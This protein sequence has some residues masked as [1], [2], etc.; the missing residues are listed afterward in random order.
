MALGPTVSA[1]QVADLRS[2]LAAGE[3]PDEPGEL[4]GLV[5]EL[6][7]LKSTICARQA[8]AAVAYDAARREDEELGGVPAA[9]RGR[10][11]AAELALAR[12]ESVHRGQ[13]LLAFAKVG[14]TEMPHLLERLADGTL[15]EFRA[16]LAL[17]ETACL[18]ADHRALVDEEL[19]ADP[20]AL[21]GIGTRALV[22]RV[23]TIA[24]E[25]DPASIAERAS[26]AVRDRHVSIRPAPD[27]M[28][29]LTAL[30]PVAQGVA[31]HAQLTR[32]AATM[33][34]TGDERRKGQLMADLLVAR[35]TGVPVGDGPQPPAVPVGVTLTLPATTLAGGHAP[36]LVDA[37]PVPAEMA[38]LLVA[39]SL[40]AG[41]DTWFRQLYPDHTGR[42][43]AMASKQR[44]FPAGLADFLSVRDQGICRTPWCGAPI[45]HLDHVEPYADGGPT[46][47]DNGQGTCAA[48]NHAKQA[49]GWRQHVE[50]DGTVE[51]VT[52]SG[53]RYRSRAPAP[54]GWRT[55]LFVKTGHGRYTLVA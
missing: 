36:G 33:T 5:A 11:V 3:L 44:I 25:L 9:H 50:P 24:Y 13:A 10:G 47:A 17:R 21:D 16:M 20:D 32:D 6:E 4:I 39:A 8:D 48:C 23:R 34:A 28:V 12:R 53:H 27:T 18:S 52:P 26:N 35:T 38:R 30:L 42:L 43:V 41:L 15:S 54:P 1:A 31:L 45:R 37:E 55:P 7:A 19:F 46:T 14:R 51:T 29:R 40:D 2:A 49:P 22:A